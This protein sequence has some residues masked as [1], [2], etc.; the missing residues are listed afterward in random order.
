MG[1]TAKLTIGCIMW[2]A[3][4]LPAVAQL[5][6][7][8]ELHGCRNSHDPLEKM[9]HCSKVIATSR[10]RT[11]LEVAFNSR[12]LTLM[13]RQRF[14]EAASDFSAVINLNPSIAG[15][16][17][18]RQNAYR[19]AGQFQ[20]A[21]RRRA[22]D[23]RARAEGQGCWRSVPTALA[24]LIIRL[25]PNA[26]SDILR[27]S[28]RCAHCGGKGAPVIRPSWGGMHTGFAASRV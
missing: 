19:S 16:Y 12:G 14:L 6:Q 13:E 7:S 2:L 8:F 21:A 11:A 24:P 17:D 23:C 1:M 27:R 15:Y 20:A 28:A 26:S 9:D 18:N 22:A 25:G 3:S 4:V 10:N 5:N